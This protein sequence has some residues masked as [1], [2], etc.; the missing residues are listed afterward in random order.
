MS[1]E[2]RFIPEEAFTFTKTPRSET[3][4]PVEL[5]KTERHELKDKNGNVICVSVVEYWDETEQP[6]Q[7]TKDAP[8][9]QLKSFVL[10][11]EGK[12]VS[13]LDLIVLHKPVRVFVSSKAEEYY[14]NPSS[15]VLIVPPLDHSIGIAVTLHELGHAEQSSLAFFESINNSVRQISSRLSETRLPLFTKNLE[16][17]FADVVKN[18]PELLPYVPPPELFQKLDQLRNLAMGTSE[19][20]QEIDTLEKNLNGRLLNL[21][22]YIG[23]S[24]YKINQS[25]FDK[26]RAEAE[27]RMVILKKQKSDLEKQL[28]ENG[29]DNEMIKKEY[30][31][32]AKPLEALLVMMEKAQE[33]DATKRAFRV[34]SFIHAEIGADLMSPEVE[35]TEKNSIFFRKND[36]CSD[37]TKRV[38][39]NLQKFGGFS[40]KGALISALGTY[41]ALGKTPLPNTKRLI[42]EEKERWEKQ[43]PSGV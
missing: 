8:A 26:R 4:E 32:L 37:S 9:R 2:N 3:K 42:Q 29:K 41:D 15:R 22:A 35:L 19:I 14:F 21:D 6:Y 17:I 43:N 34:M 27:S 10:E 40:A 11:K 33:R 24:P 7:E 20:D 36:E 18:F 23:R 28:L 16:G 12:S 1:R 31:E 38:A 13:V 30:E 5:M 25:Q 39:D